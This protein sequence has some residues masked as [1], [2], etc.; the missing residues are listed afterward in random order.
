MIQQPSEKKDGMPRKVDCCNWL[1]GRISI[2]V[3]MCFMSKERMIA[4]KIEFFD[5]E[6]TGC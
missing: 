3:E 5:E 1:N 4:V 6:K 2:K